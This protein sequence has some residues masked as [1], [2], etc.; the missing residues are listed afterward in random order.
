[1]WSFILL[2]NII[3]PTSHDLLLH[4]HACGKEFAFALDI[5]NVN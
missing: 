3:I 2:L 4:L 1:M 5:F